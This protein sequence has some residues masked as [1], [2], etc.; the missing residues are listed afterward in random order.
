TPLSINT[1]QINT[2][3]AARLTDRIDVNVDY[4]GQ[5]GGHQTSSGGSGNFSYKF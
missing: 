1:A 2:G 5:Y 4:I 3:F